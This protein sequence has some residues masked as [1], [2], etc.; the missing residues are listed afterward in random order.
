MAFHPS[1]FGV[2]MSRPSVMTVMTMV[3]MVAVVAVDV[4][5]TRNGVHA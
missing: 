5:V 4:R 3:A 2:V 1:A